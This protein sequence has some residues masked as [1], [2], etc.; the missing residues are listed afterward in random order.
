MIDVCT[1]TVDDAL[2]VKE[3]IQK[4]VLRKLEGTGYHDFLKHLIETRGNE[5]KRADWHRALVRPPPVST[6]FVESGEAVQGRSAEDDPLD[7][8]RHYIHMPK[9]KEIVQENDDA[10]ICKRIDIDTYSLC[11]DR[12]FAFRAVTLGV[13]NYQQANEARNNSNRRGRWYLSPRR[14]DGG[15]GVV[16]DG[17][18]LP[19]PIPVLQNGKVPVSSPAIPLWPWRSRRLI[20]KIDTRYGTL[21]SYLYVCQMGVPKCT[22]ESKLAWSLVIK[23]IMNESNRVGPSSSRVDDLS[24]SPNPCTLS[25]E[26]LKALD[27]RIREVHMQN[28]FFVERQTQVNLIEEWKKCGGSLNRHPMTC[29]GVPRPTSGASGPP[30]HANA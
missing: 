29:L 10:W 9:L 22:P 17:E 20:G 14:R 28:N 2:R 8:R 26:S 4:G 16:D 7:P 6:P 5:M 3:N 19:H 21:G 18:F 12:I 23:F 1:A 15:P 25:E 27:G 24:Y 11:T 13:A 30:A